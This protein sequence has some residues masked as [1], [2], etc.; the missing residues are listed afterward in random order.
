MEALGRIFSSTRNK[1]KRT[2]F[3]Y[4]VNREVI[5]EHRHTYENLIPELLESEN[6]KKYVSNF[7]KYKSYLKLHRNESDAVK[8]WTKWFQMEPIII[9]STTHF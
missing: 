4:Q 3:A 9:K 1:T 6:S 5:G 2:A 7:A 8:I